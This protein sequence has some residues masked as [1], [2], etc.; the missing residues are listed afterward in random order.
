MGDS[1]WGER[2]SRGEWKPE[3]APLPSPIFRKPWQ[4][5]EILT[6]LFAP[7]GL[8][9]PVNLVYALLAVASWLWFT[10]SPDQASRFQVWWVAEI[11]VRNAALLVLVAGGLHLRLYAT[12][13]QGMK[14]K[15]SSK[16]MAAHDPKFL[17]SNQTWDNVFWNLVS[18]CTIWTGYEAVTLWAYSNHLIP[19]V[20]WKA[21]PVY[22]VVLMLVVLF[23]RHFHFYWIHRLIHTKP[24]YKLCHFIHHRN[25]NVGPWSGL[26]MHPIE[27]LFYFSS[28]LLH[29]IVP[30]NPVHAIFNLMN[31]GLGPALGHSGFDVLVTS[32]KDRGLK[33]D[34]YFHYLHH[35]YFTVNYGTEVMPLDKWFGS[36]HDGTPRAHEAMMAKRAEARLKP[37]EENTKE[38][39]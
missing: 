10:P 35:K 34:T 22:C 24:M 3:K 20:S 23:W 8:L 17:F 11:Y 7:E 32:R 6:Y 26:S 1:G 9:W 21:H 2:D 19:Y 15:F 25:V 31:A 30:S 27:H 5:G 14:F 28:V 33:A 18:G 39:R 12:R 38:G 29:W 16:W 4:P 37:S 13:G 36:W